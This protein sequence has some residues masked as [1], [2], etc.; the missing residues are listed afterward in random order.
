MM[1]KWPHVWLTGS[2]AWLFISLAYFISMLAIDECR[3]DFIPDGMIFVFLYIMFSLS[4]VLWAAKV[5]LYDS[6]SSCPFILVTILFGIS[7]PCYGISILVDNGNPH[8]M[9]FDNVCQTLTTLEVIFNTV[10]LFLMGTYW[11]S[12]T[13]KKEEETSLVVNV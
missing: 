13:N 2:S 11:G 3:H 9:G 8:N 12:D 7:I 6:C 1:I 5:L 4:L 10:I